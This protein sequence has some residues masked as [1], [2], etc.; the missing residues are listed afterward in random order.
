M[1]LARNAWQCGD[2]FVTS[3]Q[4]SRE[5]MA[6]GNAWKH[7]NDPPKGYTKRVTEKRELRSTPQYTLDDL[8][9]TPF[10]RRRRYD[11]EGRRYYVDVERNTS[12]T[13]IHVM[14]DYLRY[15]VYEGA[16]ERWPELDDEPPA[17]PGPTGRRP[18]ALHRPAARRDCPSLRP[19]LADQPLPGPV[20]RLQ[21]VGHRAPPL[22]PPGGR[23]GKV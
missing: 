19:R 13:G 9:I 6:K 12:P 4:K 1:I 5:T 21:H 20:P 17:L 7:R 14:D 11:E 22:S 8:Y 15:L 23:R 2:L 10:T 3:R 18:A 16:K